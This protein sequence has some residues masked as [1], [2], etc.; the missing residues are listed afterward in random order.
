MGLLGV[1]LAVLA[2]F[3]FADLAYTLD[4]YLVH[5]DAARYRAT[6]GRHH[7][8]YNGAKNA[9]QLNAYELSTY[10]SAAAVSVVAMSALS[11]LTGNPGFVLGAVLKY[12][13][14]LLLHLYQHR[15]WGPVPLRRQ[16]LPAP[17][18]HW[19]LV[20]AR[21]HAFHHSDPDDPIFTYAET[22]AGFD[23]ILE[24][25]HPWLSRLTKNGKLPPRG[26]ARLV[27]SS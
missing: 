12:V 26:E 11:L 25:L 1:L 22:W 4:H 14:S 9:S 18:R 13:H 17:R 7:R 10:T 5:H 24:R 27:R 23:R 15:W 8:R 21:R 20:S 16:R 6:H 2:F 3:F 19:G